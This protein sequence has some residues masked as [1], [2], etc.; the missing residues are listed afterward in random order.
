MMVE[1]AVQFN[2]GSNGVEQFAVLIEMLL[3]PDGVY[4]SLISHL[5]VVRGR[6]QK[7]GLP[8]QGRLYVRTVKEM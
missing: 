1:R 6:E 8:C 4:K 7:E 5:E 2:G 3:S